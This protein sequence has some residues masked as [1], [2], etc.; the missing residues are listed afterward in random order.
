MFWTG[1]TLGWKSSQGEESFLGDRHWWRGRGTTAFPHLNVRFAI[2]IHHPSQAVSRILV[3]VYLR[4]PSHTTTITIHHQNRP[5][6]CRFPPHPARYPS[7]STL[8][9]SRTVDGGV[10]SSGWSFFFS[11]P[12]H[13]TT[14][15]QIGSGCRELFP[16]V[17]SVVWGAKLVQTPFR[18]CGMLMTSLT[19]L[20]L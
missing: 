7:L 18:S 1:H 5:R 20:K 11:S 13:S 4:N 9:H 2:T 12:P 10:L 16:K 15:P 8:S 14:P 17:C 6:H 3:K 19:N